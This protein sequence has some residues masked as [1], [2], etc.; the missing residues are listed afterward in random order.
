MY[1]GMGRNIRTGS[2]VEGLGISPG[3][4]GG[5]GLK[6]QVSRYKL[7]RGLGFRVWGLGFGV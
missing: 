1:G 4:K 3:L 5:S 7:T 2:W 6:V